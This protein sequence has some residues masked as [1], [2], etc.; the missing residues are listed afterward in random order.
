M[1]RVVQFFLGSC[2]VRI[3]GAS[4]EWALGRMAQARILTRE[5]EPVDEFTIQARILRRDLARAAEAAAQAMCELRLE[6]AEGFGVFA[7][8]LRRRW[9]FPVCM[10]LVLAAGYFV[11]KFVFFYRVSGNE[12]VPAE[13]I[14][15]ELEEL[16]V[17]FGTYGP[18][19]KPQ[20]LKN[21]MLLRIPELQ[22]LT[23][24]QNG[25]CAEVVVRERPETEPVADRRTPRDIVASRAGVI[26]ETLCFEGNCLVAP[27]QAV[28]E[29]Q[30]LVSAYTDLEFKTQVSA[31]SAEIYAQTLRRTET[32][33]P[34]NV[35]GKGEE[36]GRRRSVSLLVGKKRIFLW[37]SSGNSGETCDKI[38]KRKLFTLPGGYSLPIGLEIVT[39]IAYDTYETALEPEAAQEALEQLAV[40]R[41]RSDLIAGT[42]EQVS[43]RMARED[44]LLRLE[45]AAE[46]EEM[47]ARPQAVR[48][49][50]AAQDAP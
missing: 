38:T 7:A 40:Q 33:L 45:T 15:R 27:G 36:T 8:G 13:R 32:V 41:I 35:V 28:E 26:T 4:P 3:T 46:C 5:A 48:I 2:V 31:A 9:L 16:G 6:R 25:M 11:P 39:R 18:K 29:G 20:A 49:L 23:V 30:L 12:R 44:G 10:A 34:D 1:W 21:R 19:I 47:I 42:V 22:W 43:Y 14:L 50:P 24:T 17:G 37:G